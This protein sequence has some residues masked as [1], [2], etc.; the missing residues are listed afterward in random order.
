MRIVVLTSET[1]A[2]V[3]ITNRL[4]ARYDVAGIVIER[5]PLAVSAEEKL[6]RRRALVRRY[7]WRRAL[8]KLLYNAVRRRWLDQGGD[9]A[10]REHFFPGTECRYAREVPTLVVPTVNGAECAAFVGARRPDVIAICG[11][12]VVKPEIFSL[13]GRGALN[14]HTGITPEYRS[15]D[16]IFWAL[17]RGDVGKVGVTVH[18]VDQG[19]DTGPILHQQAVPLYAHDCLRTIY[20]R[21]VRTGAELYERA[22]DEVAAGTERP[23]RRAEVGGRSYLSVDLGLFQYLVFAVRFRWL[24]RRW[25]AEPH[26]REGEHGDR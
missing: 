9:L 13:A 10:L 20:Q 25:P 21:C 8:N 3:W 19:I 15:A 14:I 16:P 17:Y 12:G 4:L 26:R 18:F 2:N 5:R 22:L 1:P 6:A 24:R 11:T 23:Y 7:G